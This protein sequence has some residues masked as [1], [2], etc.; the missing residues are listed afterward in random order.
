MKFTAKEIPIIELVIRGFGNKQIATK[1]A[2]SQQAVKWHIGNIFRKYQVTTRSELAA[3]FLD[4]SKIAG[5]YPD[6]ATSQIKCPVV[7]SLKD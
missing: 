3:I 2:L 4:E 7:E 5:L 6:G 1:L